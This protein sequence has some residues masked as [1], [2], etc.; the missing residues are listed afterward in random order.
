M[1]ELFQDLTVTYIKTKKYDS[2]FFAN[3]RANYSDISCLLKS[4][5]KLIQDLMVTYIL[6][7]FGAD[8]S[9]FLDMLECKQSQIQ[10]F[11]QTQGQITPDV[12]ILFVP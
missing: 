2:V 3:S 10:Q 8:W 1:I 4:T 9:I 12:L 5:I 6:T 7:K 11:F